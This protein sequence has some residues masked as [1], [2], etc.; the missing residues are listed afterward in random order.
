[1]TVTETIPAAARGGVTLSLHGDR[2]RYRSPAGALTPDL[3]AA[4]TEHKPAL[5]HIL[6]TSPDSPEYGE[7]LV[8]VMAALGWGR[9]ERRPRRCY[10]C[11]TVNWR[12]R[13]TGGWICA[14]C[15][16]V[17]PPLARTAGSLV[18][19]PPPSRAHEGT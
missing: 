13:P 19:T 15:H 1:V 8:G 10:A 9:V 12:E 2:L 3:R 16:G 4:V 14:T 11:R 7:A 18:T 6:S 17:A 5:I